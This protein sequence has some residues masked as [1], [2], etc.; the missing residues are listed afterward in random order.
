MDKREL[1]AGIYYRLHGLWP[2]LAKPGVRRGFRVLGWTMLVTWLLFVALVLV[3]RYVVLPKVG[4][5]Q[6]E[7]E[8]AASNAVGQPVKIGKISAR[9]SGLNPDLVLDQD[10]KS[11][12]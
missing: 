3:L 1:R 10:R 4:D 7:I 5:Y 9:W 8:Q 2:W 12:V 11:V 6:T